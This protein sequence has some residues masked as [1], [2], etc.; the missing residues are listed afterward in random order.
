[1]P[2]SLPLILVVDDDRDS[3]LLLEL[4]L[5]TSGFAVMTASNGE[6]ALQ[7]ARRHT[8]ALILLDLAMPVMDGFTF[9]A[10]QLQDR[11]LASIPII[12]V[13]GR[14][15]AHQAAEQLRAAACIPKP[16]DLETVVLRV[17]ALAVC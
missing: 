4:A 8:P 16:F 2:I 10:K 9:R 1:L 7:I 12:C 13:S 14:H 15:D 5:S 3:R 17:M 11:S 6:E